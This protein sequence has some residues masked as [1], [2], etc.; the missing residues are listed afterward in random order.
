LLVLDLIQNML[1]HQPGIKKKLNW[2]IPRYLWPSVKKTQQKRQ[3]Y[4]P[5]GYD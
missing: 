4:V 5:S 1:N 2:S 3:K